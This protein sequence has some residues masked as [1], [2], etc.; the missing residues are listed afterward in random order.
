MS[1]LTQIKFLSILDF[2]FNKTNF[3]KNDGQKNIRLLV[4]LLF[5][6]YLIYAQAEENK[7]ITEQIWLD[8]Y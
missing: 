6:G 7:S 8:Y 4:L 1:N 2:G 3:F 5:S